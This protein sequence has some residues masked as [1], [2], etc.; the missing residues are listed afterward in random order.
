MVAQLSPKTFTFVWQATH[1]IN[2]LRLQN[3][4]TNTGTI[5]DLSVSSQAETFILDNPLSDLGLKLS[6][7]Q[8]NS[9]RIQNLLQ[10][11]KPQSVWIDCFPA[12][13]DVEHTTIFN[14]LSGDAHYQTYI[15]TS[16]IDLIASYF[17]HKIK[18][19]NLVIKG[20]EAVG[21]SGDET[22]LTLYAYAESLAKQSGFYPH[23]SVWGGI[24]TPE[25]ATALLLS[26][27]QQIIF[28]H[29]HLL[30]DEYTKILSTQLTNRLTNLQI[31]HTKLLSV[32]SHINFRAYDK[33]NSRA[34]KDFMT[35]TRSTSLG[36]D[37]PQSAIDILNA[38]RTNLHDS[39][40]EA[41][42]L[43]EVGIETAFAQTFCKRFGTHAARAIQAFSDATITLINSAQN[44]P[45]EPKDSP[46][47]LGL[48]CKYPIIQGAM[49]SITDSPGFA[50]TVAKAGGLPTFAL[51][52][53]N[54]ETLERELGNLNTVMGTF[55]YAINIITLSE[56]PHRDEQLG[57]IKKVKPPFVVISAGSPLFAQELLQE[58]LDVI[59]VTSDTHLMRLAWENGIRYV[60]CEGHEAGGHI[61]NHS[62]LT[63]AQSGV[64]LRRSDNSLADKPLILAGGVFDAASARR[65][66]LFGAEAI[67]VGT[68]YLATSEIVHHQALHNLYQKMVIQADFGDT[69]ITGQSVGLQV[70]SLLSPKV[71]LI[72]KQEDQFNLLGKDETYI[73]TELET[74]SV[75]SLTIAARGHY[76]GI[77]GILTDE[78]CRA[79][80]QYMCGTGAG[81]LNSV[82]SVKELHDNLTDMEPAMVLQKDK[83]ILVQKTPQAEAH[84]RVAITGMAISNSLGNSPDE[85]W[86]ASYNLKCGITQVPPERWDHSQYFSPKLNTPGK[87]YCSVGAFTSLDI[88]R[89]ELG[90]SPHDFRTM[91]HSTKLTL[92]LAQ[93]A[94][95]DSGILDSDIDRERIGVIIAQNSGESAHTIGDLTISV[96]A[97]EIVQS[98]QDTLHLDPSTTDA[99][100][101]AITQGRISTDDTTLLGR[102]SC[103]AGGFV[104]NKYNF[105]GVSFAVTAA[106]ATGLVALYNGIQLIRN[107]ILDVAIIGGGE[108]LLHPASYLEFSALGALGGKDTG[109]APGST[110][111]PFDPDRDGM[112]LGEGGAMLVL[113]RQSSAQ[114]RG[115][116]I[117][118]NITGVG[119]SNNDLGMIESVAATQQLAIQASFNDVDY[120]PSEVDLV[121]CHATAT[122]TGDPE[123]VKALKAIYPQG[124]NTVLASFKSQIGHT[125]GTSG[126]NSLIRGICAMNQKVLP[127]T[128]NYDTQDPEIDLESWGFRVCHTPE[129]WPHNSDRPRRFQVNAFGFGGANYVVQLEQA[130]WYPD[131]ED[132]PVDLPT[133]KD[134]NLSPP[135]SLP[136]ISCYTTLFRDSSYLIGVSGS[137]DTTTIAD[138]L[139][140]YLAKQEITAADTRELN[141]SGIFAVKETTPQ[142]LGL[143]FAGQGTHYK[144]MGKEL[145]ETFPTIRKWMDTIANLSEFN[146]LEIMF[147]DEDSDLRKTVWQQPALFV[148]EYSI[149]KQLEDFHLQP[150]VLAG[151]SMGELTALAV[152]GVFG[153][154]DA[155]RIISKRANCMDKA[156]K[157]VDDPGAMIAVDA[158]EDVLEKL[159]QDDADLYFTNYNSPHQTVIGGSTDAINRLSHELESLKYW[160]HILSVS[161]AFHSPIMR[162]IRD[163]LG[164]YLADI[165][166]K[167]PKIPVVSNTTRQ[168]Y[169][170]DIDEI[171]KIIISHLESPVHWQSNMETV[172]NDYNVDHFL[173]I[174]P[175]DT[176]CRFLDDIVPDAETVYTCY[177]DK[178]IQTF[179]DAIARL[180]S[181]GHLKA[182]N[183][184]TTLDISDVR[185]LRDTAEIQKII[186]QEINTYALQGIEKYLKPAILQSIQQKLDP[187]FKATDL[188]EYFG[189]SPQVNVPLPDLGVAESSPS[190][191]VQD[192]PRTEVIEHASTVEVLISIIMDATGYE[193]SEIEPEMDIRQD[194]SIRSSR[195]PVIM[196][197]V[198]KAFSVTIR[199]EDFMGIKT[200]AD[201]A[202]Q[203]DAT[204]TQ[205]GVDPSSN[206]G[207]LSTQ[208]APQDDQDSFTP[209]L[210]IKRLVPHRKELPPA[211]ASLLAL[212][213]GSHILLLTTY[214]NDAVLE[215]EQ[216]LEERC[217]A[218]ITKIIL[219]TDAQPHHLDPYDHTAVKKYLD[220]L[221]NKGDLSGIVLVT[222]EDDPESQPS[223]AQVSPFVTTIFLFIKQILDSDKRAFCL[224]LRITDQETLSHTLVGEGLLGVLLTA[225]IEYQ[226]VLFRSLVIR[227]LPDIYEILDICFDTKQNIID[228]EL[229]GGTLYTQEYMHHKV[230][231]NTQQTIAFKEGD[232]VVIAAGAQGVTAKLAH[233]LS[234]FGST[235]ILL[236]RT[237]YDDALDY[238][239]DESELLKQIKTHYP[240]LDENGQNHTYQTGLDINNLITALQRYG[241]TIEYKTCDVTDEKQVSAT[242]AEI[243]GKHNKIDTIIHGAGILSDSF[244]SLLTADSFQKVT[245]V[246]LTGVVNLVNSVGAENLRHVIGLSS[247]AALTGNIG[248]A[249][250]CCGNRSMASY[251][252]WLQKKSD[253]LSKVFWL[254]P[255][256]GAGM[257]D[258]PE[259]KDLVKLKIGKF[260]FVDADEIAEIMVRELVSS[261]SRDCWVAPIRQLPQV[262]SVVMENVNEIENDGWLDCRQYPM[263]DTVINAD[264]KNKKQLAKRTLTQEHD[265]WINDHKPFKW[266]KHP[267]SSAIM[268]I[269]TFLETVSLLH[270]LFHVKALKNIAFKRILECPPETGVTMNIGCETIFSSKNE[271]NCLLVIG[272]QDGDEPL[273]DPKQKGYFSAKALLSTEPMMLND[274]LQ[275]LSGFSQAALM[276]KQE[277]LTYYEQRTGLVGRYRVLNTIVSLE[278]T[279]IT[280]TMIYPE[281][282]DFALQDNSQSQYPHYV[283]E[284]LMQL[285]GFHAGIKDPNDERV[286]VPTGIRKLNLLGHCTSGDTIYLSC[287]LEKERKERSIW[288]CQAI[289]DKGELLL[290]VT[291]LNMSW[292]S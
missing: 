59:Y 153:Y 44:N 141:K 286:K 207:K 82:L 154:E 202:N 135:E 263:I 235:L 37:L 161:M 67:Q 282:D 164:D 123:E 72:Q 39:D 30:T 239:Q 167:P 63:L 104:C 262:N 3:K 127:P 51:G 41:D 145:Y 50:L 62:T 100:I 7:A 140:Q 25:A 74:I 66:F 168:I 269:E 258:D 248:Q 264:F 106:C 200:I 225:Q 276:G 272:K 290:S 189:M 47:A 56:N 138:R 109:L 76:P 1:A 166:F 226:S 284:A 97:A 222:G 165:E 78:Q 111:R 201:F 137:K 103:T 198:E 90:I 257:A 217:G 251:L 130:D 146:I 108:E 75:G 209:R 208:D 17:N 88:S 31:E 218:H 71:K 38:Q 157:M 14:N 26:G 149:Y 6:W 205:Q 178:E 156:S 119:A 231:G 32:S 219:S 10:D 49:A 46:T 292:F 142:N 175:R 191:D 179:Q 256:E 96:K 129:G 112:I 73:R 143:L 53:K 204:M 214:D 288:H 70:R 227:D 87:T 121:E 281:V 177:P 128:I 116:H 131:I 11:K 266:L 69:T 147:K 81:G 126:L 120:P 176:L 144:Q 261:S 163:E 40:L 68:A 267:I 115:T 234:S 52:I 243:L 151:H 5:I 22:T 113:E 233:A 249:N 192:A 45:Y 159:I 174:G 89:K 270:P 29:L 172:H 105:Q 223:P 195:L 215:T 210:P 94:L 277:I 212:D 187:T 110:S 246:K 148:L 253:L 15:I 57:W 285:C 2:S 193:R 33:G 254:P 16:N 275:D 287:N 54:I 271:R 42:Q 232:V 274:T 240:D 79:E 55:S 85:I 83:E 19:I 117:Y 188:T 273:N 124:A 101:A 280:G 28:E 93:K 216:Y 80:G 171:K 197:A 95:A 255:I 278:D 241:S 107:N 173:E 194:L 152:S 250:Y 220:S 18:D 160:N 139:S 211:S 12:A 48:G 134:E 182:M 23:I 13:L 289:N 190:A 196:D 60:V 43:V 118:A 99:L 236:G 203:I 265:L 20:N 21:Y 35:H 61:G 92:W 125:L 122:P 34:V 185:L 221:A 150:S 24:C 114:N 291:R 184:P 238:S 132:S 181:R 155:F 260:A 199:I 133:Y 136:G 230:T 186:Q 224:H 36:D 86:H 170:D 247:I 245:D 244:I 183:E 77:N 259:V 4:K 237:E 268:T 162:V 228:I 229:D 27:A 98:I 58:G 91:T 180:Y 158:P 84:E 283:L 252:Q 206:K 65:A 64:E 213:P 242:I 169:P 9:P 279:S 102:L 8:F